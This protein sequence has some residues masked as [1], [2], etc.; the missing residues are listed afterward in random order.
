MHRVTAPATSAGRLETD[1]RTE[2]DQ[3]E[4]DQSEAD[5]PAENDVSRR[6]ALISIGKYAAYVTPAMTVLIR[7]DAALA[8]HPCNP[9]NGNGNGNGGG[10][11]NGNGGGAPH[12]CV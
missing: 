11:G 1:G 5:H 9:G 7:G 6:H 10:N 12:S 3:T 4:D 2:V 8:N